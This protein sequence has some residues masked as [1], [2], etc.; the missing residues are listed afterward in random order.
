MH[1]PCDL[2]ASNAP[3][4]NSKTTVFA[5]LNFLLNKIIHFPV[6]ESLLK[7][8]QPKREKNEIF[9]LNLLQKTGKSPFNF[10]LRKKIN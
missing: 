4:T 2:S 7:E 10:H 8:N 9:C 3:S 5:K 6:I 1:T